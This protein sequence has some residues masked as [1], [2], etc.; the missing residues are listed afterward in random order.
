[1]ADVIKDNPYGGSVAENV[2]YEITKGVGF[3]WGPYVNT[4]INVDGKA[5]TLPSASHAANP[6]VKNIPNPV[7]SDY[8]GGPEVSF[9]GRTLSVVEL[10]YKNTIK[11]E[12]WLNYFPAFQPT[13]NSIDLKA[14]PKV[15]KAFVNLAMDS[16]KAQVNTLHS[17]GEKGAVGDKAH[18]DFYDGFSTLIHADAKAKLVGTPEALTSDNIL[19]KFDELKHSIPAR[20]RHDSNLVSFCSIKAFDLYS[21]ARAKTQSYVATP[22]LKPTTT[23]VQSFGTGI[24]IVPMHGLA[25]DFVF[26]TIASTKPSSNLTQGVWMENDINNFKIFKLNEG[27]QHYRA[28]MRL[29][30]GVQYKAGEDIVYLN[31]EAK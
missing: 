11:T 22:D 13:G 1:M 4:L 3:Q 24:K 15:Q 31:S 18:L 27:E 8:D 16:I 2:I 21:E 10:M 26:A 5:F 25:D 9:G 30:M 14:N 12:Q 17:E 28:L 20:L 19:K 7:A 29:S 6:L 23:L